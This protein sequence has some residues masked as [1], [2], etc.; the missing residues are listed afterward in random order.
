M[1]QRDRGPSTSAQAIS[2]NSGSNTRHISS[3]NPT[4]TSG[5]PSR[6]LPQASANLGAAARQRS[7]RAGA[8]LERAGSRFKL[9]PGKKTLPY[10]MQQV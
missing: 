5:A 3:S 7:L 2:A 8:A 9:P 6:G 10:Q 1:S 4:R